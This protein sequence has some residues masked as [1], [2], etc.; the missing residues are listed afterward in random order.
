MNEKDFKKIIQS[1]LNIQ[2]E[3]YILNFSSPQNP[4]NI[5]KISREVIKQSHINPNTAIEKIFYEKLSTEEYKAY[6]SHYNIKNKLS[7][8]RY[9]GAK[10]KVLNRYT[11]Y[12][13]TQHSEYREPFVGGASI[14]LG[15]HPVDINVLNDKDYNVYAFLY[16]VKNYPDLL[17]QRVKETKPTINLWLEKKAANLNDK[18]ILETAFDFFF[19]NRT[20]YSGI[21]SANPLGGLTQKS[22]YK[23]DCRWNNERLCK[24]ITEMSNKLKN[25]ELLNTD[26][27]EIISREGKDVLLI[28][29]PPYYHK[30]NSLYS[31][32]MSHNDHLRLAELLKNTQ[33]KYVLT[34][35]EC[36]ETREIYMNENTYINQETWKYTVHSKKSDNNGKELFI[37]NFP[38]N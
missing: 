36:P 16:A 11:K 31:T 7:P 35:D 38:V 28:I 10:S 18:G 17:C 1:K 34:I 14:F 6:K 22:K 12:F 15:K 4:L 8:L 29:D 25:V 23:I 32:K 3:N 30:G 21:Y 9:P 24:Q 20:N 33:H 13:K 26:F 19:F 5:E 2:L 27:E 37:S